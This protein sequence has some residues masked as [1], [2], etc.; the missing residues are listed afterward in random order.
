M[1][2]SLILFASSVM[3]SLSVHSE[4]F[5]STI[6]SSTA[7]PTPLTLKY[8]L[9]LAGKRHYSEIELALSE[10]LQTQYEQKLLES[11]Y[12]FQI[13]IHGQLAA[14]KPSSLL[15]RNFLNRN[16]DH[17]LSLYV[18]KR[19]YDFGR[20][21][22]QLDVSKKKL[23]AASTQ[24]INE[25]KAHYLKILKAYFEVI[26]SDLEFLYNNEAMAIA[27]I[28]FDRAKTNFDLKKL[29]ELELL[30]IKTDY[31]KT[32]VERIQSQNKQRLRRLILAI[33]LDQPEQLPSDL[34]SPDVSTIPSFS[35]NRELPDITELQTAALKNNLDLKKISYQIEA[36]K[37]Q[38]QVFY[39]NK[40]PIISGKLETAWYSR[41]LGGDDRAVAALSI[42]IPI[43]QG[44]EIQSQVGISSAKLNQLKAIHKSKSMQLQQQVME[45]WINLQNLKQRYLQVKT[46]LSYR[47]LYLDKSRI[48]YESELKSDLGRAMVDLS[49]TQLLE[50]KVLFEIAYQWAELDII[51]N[52]DQLYAYM[53]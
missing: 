14:V 4:P 29:S 40:Y 23:K 19:L 49:A 11:K 15:A 50:K 18:T 10:Q 46:E 6:Q 38:Q 44:S 25:K 16:T 32:N 39:A 3:F 42:D 43:Y 31:E 27:F 5:L 41:E 13:G 28:Q 24:L 35:N 26:L 30:R 12:E 37:K 2:V 20:R 7:L 17:E 8:A 53:N 51:M 48:E 22:N 34:Q 1:I 47:E 45:I 52:N 21:S 33:N 36:E 9:S